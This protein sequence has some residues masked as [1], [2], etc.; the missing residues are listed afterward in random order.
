MTEKRMVE[1]QKKKTIAIIVNKL[2]NIWN[3]LTGRQ[4]KVERPEWHTVVDCDLLKDESRSED[5]FT[6]EIWEE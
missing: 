6:V 2:I 5:W 1:E 4:I 3:E